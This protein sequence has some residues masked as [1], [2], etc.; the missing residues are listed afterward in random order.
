V[1]VL[2]AYALGALLLDEPA[3]AEVEAMLRDDEAGISSVNL[4][5]ALDVALRIYGLPGD[6]VREALDPLLAASVAVLWPTEREAW[7]AAEIR[8]RHYHRRTNPLSLA[9]CLL[10][11]TVTHADGVATADPGVARVARDEGIHLVPLPDS[12]GR[13]P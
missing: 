3:A 1:I 8:S 11:A 10:L 5:E 13:R 4:A 2:D 12:S 7:R 9:D 6:R